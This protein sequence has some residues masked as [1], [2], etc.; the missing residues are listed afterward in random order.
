M[1]VPIVFVLAYRVWNK[2]TESIKWYFISAQ[3]QMFSMFSTV[4]I[5]LGSDHF[6]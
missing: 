4:Y 2:C 3:V 1:D 6:N 5:E